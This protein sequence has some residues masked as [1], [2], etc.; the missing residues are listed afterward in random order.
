MVATVKMTAQI[1]RGMRN[2]P[3]QSLVE[4]VLIAPLLLLLIFGLV[5]FARAWNIRHVVTD[6]AREGARNMAVDNG[7]TDAE[8]VANIGA[9]L[10]SAGLNPANATITLVACEG[11]NPPCLTSTDRYT[12]GSARVTISYPYTLGLTGLF[13][14]WAVEDGQ[15]N[16][17]TTF[18][19]RNE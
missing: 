16:I 14:G 5:E 8:V 11:S 4:F 1:R 13:L 10:Q 6:A 9:V 18:V 15:I 17:G 2:R 3:G 7:M 12:G 19:M